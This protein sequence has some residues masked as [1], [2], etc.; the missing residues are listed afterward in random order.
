MSELVRA[1]VAVLHGLV[2]DLSEQVLSL[3]EVLHMHLSAATMS[4]QLAQMPKLESYMT[5]HTLVEGRVLFDRGD[6]ADSIYIVLSGSL[7]SVID[8]LQFNECAPA[9]WAP[10]C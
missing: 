2:Q 3:S 9:T 6:A 10:C 8:F 4:G 5:K 1:Q 7:V